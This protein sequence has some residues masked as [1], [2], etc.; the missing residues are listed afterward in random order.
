MGFFARR[1]TTISIVYD[2]NNLGAA[3]LARL[4]TFSVV[5]RATKSVFMGKRRQSSVAAARL[6][7]TFRLLRLL[8]VPTLV[9]EREGDEG[10]P[11]TEGEPIEKVRG[12]SG[13]T[14]SCLQ[15]LIDPGL[16]HEKTPLVYIFA[17]VYTREGALRWPFAFINQRVVSLI[18]FREHELRNARQSPGLVRRRFSGARVTIG[19]SINSLLGAICI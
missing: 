18:K 13:L 5:N 15:R 4:D 12:D 3:L 9:V 16:S 1:L 14:L 7:P 17:R 11:P 8:P 19:R 10:E 6:L 2:F